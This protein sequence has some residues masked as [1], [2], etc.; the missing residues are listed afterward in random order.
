MRKT[1]LAL[2]VL[3]ATATLSAC[4]GGS[5]KEDP[6]P[7]NSAPTDL[8]ISASTVNENAVAAVIGDLSAVDSDA[9]D[10]FTFSVSDTRFAI[11]GNKL[12]LAA[13][14]KLNFETEPEVKV[15]VTVKDKAGASFAKEL[16]ITVNDVLDTYSFKNA[17]GDST[18]SYSGQTA[19]H[20][21]IEQLNHY[22]G[23]SL[24]AD[25]TSGAL[26][27][28]AAVLAKLNSYFEISA[29]DYE[30]V[31]D[32]FAI[33]FTSNTSQTV[34]SQI[35]SSQKD[36]IGKIAGRDHTG[37]HKNWDGDSD[38]DGVAEATIEF[39]GWGA[40]GVMTPETLVRHFF[41]LLATNAQT[42][43]DGSVRQ[44]IN[45]NDITELY[46]TSDGLDLKQL[47]QKFLL[48][49]V[50]YS[51]GVDDYLDDDTAGKGL[52]TDNVALESGKSYTALEHGFDEGFGYFGAARDYLEYTDEEIAKKGGRSDWQG[53]HDSNADG[54]IDLLS[55]YNFGNST[56]AAKRDLDTAGNTAATDYT[57]KAMNA[58]LAGR[59]M[60]ADNV[61]STFTDAQL[62]ELKA[63]RDI[64]VDAWER[65]IVTTVVHYI[66]EVISDLDK[67]GSADFNYA[68]TAKHWSEMKGFALGIQF[69]RFSPVTY[70]QFM[71]IHN[72]LGDKPEL[73][74]DRVADYKAGLVQART[75]LTAI[76]AFDEDNVASW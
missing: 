75:L 37:Q 74:A 54:K 59:K 12:S 43:I 2:A 22:I 53:A 31:K 58:F 24:K 40:A 56:N 18:V 35:S 14:T 7:T 57:A 47:I 72:R 10:S 66:N 71:V 36:L 13:D 21:L 9:N 16:T 34:L 41:D 65:A 25:V 76:Y 55:E 51:Q 32:S 27:D 73:S 30:L 63:Q 11:S 28:K 6:T 60:I 42:Q 39:A 44:D 68:N 67:L 15:T 52:L 33:D 26:A 49:S 46:L 20:I 19:R 62:T 1:L 29:A 64:A 38:G 17:A 50:A 48:M 3:T 8:K 70:E 4:G 5:S 69:N 61:G 23:N 45:G